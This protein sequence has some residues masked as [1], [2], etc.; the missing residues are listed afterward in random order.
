LTA[1][2]RISRL[3][4]GI[5]VGDGVAHPPFGERFWLAEQAQ[6][7]VRY[8][9]DLVANAVRFTPSGGT[10]R[11][12]WKATPQGGQFAVADSGI[13]IGIDPKRLPRPTERSCRVDRDRS[14]DA[15]GTGLG[16][17]IA[18]H[19]LNRHQAHFAITSTPGIGSRFVARFPAS[20]VAGV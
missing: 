4:D 20:H 1:T 9:E 18:K 12:S 6:V 5:S 13:G 17:A 15:G 8:G 11:L 2:V 7:A 16:L 14:R 19:S 10:V 3:P